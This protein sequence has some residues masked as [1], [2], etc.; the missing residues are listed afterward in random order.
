MDMWDMKSL[1]G[2][3]ETHCQ[4]PPT[5]PLLHV[6]YEC[7]VWKLWNGIALKGNN[8][9]CLESQSGFTPEQDYFPLNSKA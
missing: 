8:K 2:S 4:W 9:S 7:I 3:A 1:S 5:T 6:S